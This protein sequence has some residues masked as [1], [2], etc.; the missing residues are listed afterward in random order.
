MTRLPPQYEDPIAGALYSLA[1][2]FVTREERRRLKEEEERQRTLFELQKKQ[3]EL[4]IATQESAIEKQKRIDQVM[5]NT[6]VGELLLPTVKDR[7]G[8]SDKVL[9]YT[10]EEAEPMG[11]LGDIVTYAN[12]IAAEEGSVQGI[13]SMHSGILGLWQA[14]GLTEDSLKDLLKRS[15]LA[16]SEEEM[17][18]LA[19]EMIEGYNN[20]PEKMTKDILRFEQ[21]RELFLPEYFELANQYLNAE[22]EEKE[23][24]L[25][26]LTTRL[27]PFVK[28]FA[29]SA[30]PVRNLVIAGLK[31]EALAKLPKWQGQV[32]LEIEKPLLM[33]QHALAIERMAISTSGGGGG[34]GGGRSVRST[35]A[36]PSVDVN[37]VGE[38]IDKGDWTGLTKHLIGAMGITRG[39]EQASRIKWIAGAEGASGS[40][41]GGAETVTPP[42]PFVTPGGA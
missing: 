21:L 2:A 13:L 11:I 8:L 41:S 24:L 29:Q 5:R 30:E 9:N 6:K 40:V 4:S 12:R 19:K 32:G 34:G 25:A 3:A 17:S 31:P 27:E 35:T 7:L 14:G 36:T 1:E 15:P 22:G 20:N 23:K 28:L 42:N 33:L 37:K 39:S 38:F 26:E 16:G 18:K 10:I